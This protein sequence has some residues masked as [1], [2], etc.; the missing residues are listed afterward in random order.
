[1]GTK[2][3]KHVTVEDVLYRPV[4]KLGLVGEGRKMIKRG[5]ANFKVKGPKDKSH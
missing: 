3:R 5:V 2:K 1:L 4:P